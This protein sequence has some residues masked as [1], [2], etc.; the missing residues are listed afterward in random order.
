MFVTAQ[1]GLF[2]H[3]TEQLLGL[4][5][6]FGNA[7]CSETTAKRSQSRYRSPVELGVPAAGV[8]DSTQEVARAY[9]APCTPEFFG[10]N[11]KDEL[12]Y[13]GRLDAS[14]MRLSRMLAATYL[15]Q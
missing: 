11:A 12:Q 15:K 2:L 13:R 1:S 4:S 8:I 5:Q 10:F 3:P 7:R 9:D 14:R 6:E